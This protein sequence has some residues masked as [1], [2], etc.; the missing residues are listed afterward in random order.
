MFALAGSLEAIEAVRS[1]GRRPAA[2]GAG[3]LP[4]FFTGFAPEGQSVPTSAKRPKLPL[5]S[6]ALCH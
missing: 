6:C 2:I 1:A 3:A 5:A 4:P